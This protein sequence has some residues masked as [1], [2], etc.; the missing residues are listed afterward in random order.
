[1]LFFE[2]KLDEEAKKGKVKELGDGV[3]YVRFKG[4]S[5]DKKSKIVIKAHFKNGEKSFL[6]IEELFYRTIT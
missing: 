4:L 6:K 5:L 3:Y 2:L 1:M